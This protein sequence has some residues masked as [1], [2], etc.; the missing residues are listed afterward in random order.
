MSGDE[1][2]EIKKRYVFKKY[3]IRYPNFVKFMDMMTELSD[4][5][6][7]AKRKFQIHIPL[8]SRL[9]YLQFSMVVVLQN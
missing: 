3:L 7:I 1:V 2:V 5:S 4:L 8:N 9:I 6:I